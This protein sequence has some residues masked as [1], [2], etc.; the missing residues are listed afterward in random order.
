VLKLTLVIRNQRAIDALAE[1]GEITERLAADW[2]WND[3]LQRLKDLIVEVGSEIEVIG[4]GESEG[5]MEED[6]Q[7]DGW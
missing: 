7:R 5:N 2:P 1:A 6:D 3:D 4:N